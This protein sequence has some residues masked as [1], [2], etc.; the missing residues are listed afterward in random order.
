MMDLLQTM[1][2]ESGRRGDGLQEKRFREL[3]N[4]SGCEE[5]RKAFGLKFCAVVKEIEPELFKAMKWAEAEKN[6]ISEDSI[7]GNWDKEQAIRMT[8]M[9]YIRL[10]VRR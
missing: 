4:F 10:T 3:G 1:K 2:A 9:L 7:Q 6:D 5:E 8:T